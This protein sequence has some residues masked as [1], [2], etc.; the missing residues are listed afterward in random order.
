MHPVRATSILFADFA[1]SNDASGRV[2]FAY[3]DPVKCTMFV[4]EDTEETPHFD[5]TKMSSW[6]NFLYNFAVILIFIVIDQA[7]PDV[8]LTS[9]KADDEFMDTLRDHSSFLDPSF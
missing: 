5:L 2:G 3:Y 8:V 7:T 1:R 6:P 9:S 4:L